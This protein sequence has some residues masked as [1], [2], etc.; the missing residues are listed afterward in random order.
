MVY[1][2]QQHNNKTT[3]RNETRR[4]TMATRGFTKINNSIAFDSDLSLEALGLYV[5]LQHL[6]TID[7]FSIKRDYV[8]SISGYGET[9]FRRVWK[10]LK[11]KCVLVESKTSNKGRYE[12]VYTLKTNEGDNNG[13]YS[14]KK[15]KIANKH[16]DSNGDAPLDGQIHI[17]D[18][19]E[20]D[21]QQEATITNEDI[22]VVV[23]ATGLKD[24]EVA[25]LL[26]VASNDVAKVI[27]CHKY[28]A[29]QDNV[30]NVFSYTK[31]A[32]KTNKVLKSTKEHATKGT[33]TDYPQRIYDFNK[34]E[35]A[36]LYGDQYD[37][38]A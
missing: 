31:W 36:L 38:P 29:A 23:E 21:Q 24:V 8:K 1:F 18:V 25:E 7:N 6:S 26:K 37:L 17:D 3:Q 9:A 4:C 27:E 32:I 28:T 19:L 11:D 14:V 2:I 20:V 30:K 22:A 13:N 12:Y 33:F 16:V 35:R 5:K 15:K 10:E 34:L